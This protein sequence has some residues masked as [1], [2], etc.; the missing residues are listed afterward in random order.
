MALRQR[1][2]EHGLALVA[3]RLTSAVL[4]LVHALVHDS[5][6]VLGLAVRVVEHNGAVRVADLERVAALG[7]CVHRG[8]DRR[9]ARHSGG[10]RAELVA[11]RTVG[12]EFCVLA[13]G[14]ASAKTGRG[15]RT[16]RARRRVRDQQLAR[17][18]LRSTTPDCKPE[19][20]LRIVE[21]SLI[22]CKNG[23]H[24]SAGNQS[25]AVLVRAL[26]ECH[27]DLV[28]RTTPT[29]RGWPIF[30]ARPAERAPTISS[31]RCTTR[32][33]CTTW[34]RSAIPDAILNKPGPLDDASGR[35][36]AGT[37]SSASA[38]SRGAALAEVGRARALEPRALGRRRL[39]G[40]ARGRGDPEAPGSS[41]SAT[42][43]TRW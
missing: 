6:R 11:F 14:V 8:L 29:C 12:D 22:E 31:L 40:R 25:K 1:P 32:P 13:T 21:K 5:Q 41:P 2:D 36:C 24:Q 4:A 34:A 43:L 26:W 27:P 23:G 30:V 38:S 28:P 9:C 20:A 15:A 42:P 17:G 39:P 18:G 7:E 10:Q 19:D 33:S 37:R 35:S 16:H 3:G